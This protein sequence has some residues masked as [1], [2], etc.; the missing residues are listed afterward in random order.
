MGTGKVG[1]M[2]N[3]HEQEIAHLKFSEYILLACIFGLCLLAA[4][5]FMIDWANFPAWNII[6]KLTPVVINTMTSSQVISLQMMGL[7]SFI[8]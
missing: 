5:V 6:I 8:L 7:E 3:E 1:F 2:T 4:M